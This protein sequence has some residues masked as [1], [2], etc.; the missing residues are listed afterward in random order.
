M[1]AP[2][3]RDLRERLLLAGDAGHPAAEIARTMG[4]SA[5]SLRRWKA[6]LQPGESLAP[7]AM[8]GRPRTLPPEQ[9]AHLVAQVADCPDATLN[10][11]RDRLIK[12]QG[13]AVSTSTVG[14]T[15][16]R[17]GVPLKKRPCSPPNAAPSNAPPGGS[18]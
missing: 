13:R 14:R 5:R 6:R 4:V 9:E 18:G 17:H 16:R 7:K 11:H 10:E 1:P 8:S 12:E 15:L 2:Y 3:S